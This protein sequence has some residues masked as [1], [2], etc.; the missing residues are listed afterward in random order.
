MLVTVIAIGSRGDVQPYIALAAGLRAAGY[1][2]RVATH[3]QFADLL[4]DRGIERAAVETNPR[5]LLEDGRAQAM[6]GAGTNALRFVRNFARLLEPVT[7]A[8]AR[9]CCRACEGADAVVLSDVGIIA[10]FHQIAEHFDVPYCT[11]L[12]QPVAPTGDF[13]SPFLPELPHWIPFGR[14]LYNRWS[15]RAFLALFRHFFRGVMPILREELGLSP[16]SPREM[17]RVA[18]AE[19]A[20]VLHGFSPSVLPRPDD[21]PPQYRVVGYWFLDAAT[22]WSPS[23]QLLEFL[24]AGPPPV[25]I[26]FGSMT[27]EDP[28]AATDLVVEALQ[29]AGAR[30][31]VLTGSGALLPH[32]LPPDVLPIESAPHDWLLPRM[33]AAVHHG[34]AGTTAAALRSGAPSIV[35]PFFADQPFW[36]RTVHGLGVGPRPIPRGRLT[37]DRLAAAIGEALSHGAMRR[38]A[39]ELGRRIRAEDGVA[40][41]VE[42]MGAHFEA[43]R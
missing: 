28:R 33:S 43:P 25:Y 41:A 6:L 29:R 9:D 39:A 10:G 1:E 11:A 7:R 21:W 2:V 42:I 30:G 8:L 20:P 36:A 18:A 5:D 13:A 35:V 19:D 23:P 37:A 31:I 40:R 14:R 27:S 34:G 15:H 12:L 22:H 26:G 4:E 17:R 32:G 24:D 16:L 3:D 38:R